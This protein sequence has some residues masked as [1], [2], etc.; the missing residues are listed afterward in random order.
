MKINEFKKA[1]PLLLKNN[2]V[3]FVWGYQGIGKTQ[4]VS[5]YAK[6]NGLGFVH[7]HLATQEVGDL[8]G[9]LKHNDDG[10]VS[11]SRPEWFPTEG[12]GIIFL[13]EFNRSHPDVLQAMFPFTT[14]KTMHTHKLPDG[15][16]I[17]A[18]GNFQSADF[19]TT[20]ISDAALMSRFCHIELSPSAE[21]FCVFADSRKA[22][23]V[24]DFIRDMPELLEQ[25]NRSKHEITVTPDRRA[26]LEM[27]APLENEDMEDTIRFETYAGIV[28]NT[29]T[30]SFFAHK[31]SAQSRLRLKDILGD[32]NK[33]KS[34]V[35]SLI[36]RE[37][38]RLDML[39]SPL[40]ELYTHLETDPEYLTEAGTKNLKKYFEVIPLELLARAVKKLGTIRFKEKNNL[41]SDEKLIKLIR[42]KK[43]NV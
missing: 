7:L 37:E 32:Y 10:T 21:E 24:S 25:K 18:A 5:Q 33:V 23:T 29:A 41:L 30:S 38:T 20:D 6:E 31:K 15:W 26:W 1:L 22:F 35:E 34:K 19:V 12:K 8:V 2:I 28:G 42:T 39:S 13:D 40:E 4:I 17:V 14:N 36:S 27:I 43:E 3:P 9:L 11:H 16:K